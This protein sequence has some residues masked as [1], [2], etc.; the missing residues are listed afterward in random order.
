MLGEAVL[1][2][3]KESLAKKT[4]LIFRPRD[5]AR[6][7]AAVTKR[8]DVLGLFNPSEYQQLLSADGEAGYA[9]I[10]ALA[11]Q[12]VNL[13]SYFF[14]D[15]AQFTLLEQK[16]LP[17][18]VRRKQKSKTLKIWSA[19]CAEGEEAYSVAIVL[20]LLHLKSVEW[21]FM[22]IGTDI[23]PK[24]IA[25]AK[26]G[27]YQDYAFRRCP[28]GLR[29]R[30]FVHEASEWVVR[31]GIKK[32][33][34]FHQHNLIM[35]PFL[36]QVGGV[37]II[38][39]RNV[40]IYLGKEVVCKLIDKFYEVLPDGGILLTGPGELYLNRQHR[41]RQ[42]VVDGAVFYYKGTG[43]EEGMDGTTTLSGI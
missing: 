37:D 12:L 8:M 15:Q 20:S 40:M 38:L 11:S 26:E 13:E 36:P 4:G 14:R 28:Y 19:G 42:R 32:S 31:P 21:R 24:A 1:M 29:E 35:D 25:R 6:F 39:C 10:I 22:V 41:F 9:E 2:G 27:R 33:V 16:L 7:A 23:S 43:W 34:Q 17:T 5:D 3:M 30:F 18:I